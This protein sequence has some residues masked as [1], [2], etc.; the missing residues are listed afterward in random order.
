MS[1]QIFKRVTLDDLQLLLSRGITLHPLLDHTYW[2]L[3]THAVHMGSA[4]FTPSSRLKL[5]AQKT[6]TMSPLTKQKTFG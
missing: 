4:N 1:N 3:L 6:N 5:Y 2:T